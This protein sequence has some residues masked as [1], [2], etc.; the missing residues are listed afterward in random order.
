[1]Q[2]TVHIVFPRWLEVTLHNIME[3]TAHHVDVRVPLYAL[4]DAQQAIEREFGEENVITERFSLAG[5]NRTF[6][7]CQLYDFDTHQW[8]SF[9]GHATT[10]PRCVEKP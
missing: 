6:R 8:L 2:S 7:T 3:H 5:M 9:N 10:A 4:T 1:V